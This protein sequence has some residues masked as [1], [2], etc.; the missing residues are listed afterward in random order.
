MAKKPTAKKPA[1]K[2]SSSKPAAEEAA[3]A[4]QAEPP[5]NAQFG[6]LVQFVKDV[7]FENPNAPMTLQAPGDNPKLEINV[8]VDAI[9]HTEDVFEVDIHFE[10]KA[11]SDVG[12]IYNVELVYATLFRV[13][14]I[15]DELLRPVLFV[16]GPTIMFPY[17]RRVVSDLTR[18]GG[19]QPLLVDPIDFATLFQQN[20]EK[21]VIRDLSG[22]V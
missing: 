5:E 9:K 1:S 6:I 13:M 18:D 3:T 11:E 12:V 20:G 15:P 21:A 16:D 7:S 4:A 22:A 14:N 2:K 8:R 19:Y 10:A 17:L